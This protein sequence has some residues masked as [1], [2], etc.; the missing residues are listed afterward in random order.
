MTD[1]SL[2]VQAQLRHMLSERTPAERLRM[3][4]SMY[5]TARTLA[6]AGIAMRGVSLDERA[7]QVELFLR[8]YGRELSPEQRLAVVTMLGRAPR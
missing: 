3:C 6:R 1:T 8:F 4:T 5:R 7:M 2:E